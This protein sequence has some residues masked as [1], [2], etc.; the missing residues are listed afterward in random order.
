[1][2]PEHELS[3]KREFALA[4]LKKPLR[5]P[6]DSYDIGT[7]IFGGDTVS[8]MRAGSSW[9]SDPDVIRFK[10]ELA[11]EFGPEVSLPSREEL[12]LSI[13]EIA[14]EKIST[15]SGEIYRVEPRDREKLLRL[16]AEVRGFI[17]NDKKMAANDDKQ[18][19]PDVIFKKYEDAT[20]AS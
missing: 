19:L 8:A 13:L 11:K 1:M 20:S 2:S 5:K 17:K 14:N 7:M 10:E 12:A 16:Y 4:M 6:Q 3:L 15:G 9:P 18:G